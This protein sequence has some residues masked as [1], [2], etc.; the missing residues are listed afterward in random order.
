MSDFLLELSKNPQARKFIDSLGLP[1]SLPEP[2]PRARGAYV[3][4]PLDNET[5]ATYGAGSGELAPLL[6]RVIAESGAN[7]I[8]LD[9]PEVLGH[10][11]GPAEAWA[12]RAEAGSATSPPEGVKAAAVILDATGFDS[13]ESLR[14]LYD[15]V[16][17]SFR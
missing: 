17:G 5:V 6:A 14:G 10:Y 12:R 8:V 3:E 13:P 15:C 7:A 4:R 9:G 2:L 16:H 11:R 1:L